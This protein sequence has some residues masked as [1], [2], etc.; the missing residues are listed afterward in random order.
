M[1]KSEQKN[2][3]KR[4]R[5]RFAAKLCCSLFVSPR[6][7]ATICTLLVRQCDGRCYRYVAFRLR[8]VAADG[9]GVN[10]R[11]H[12]DDDASQMTMIFRRGVWVVENRMGDALFTLCLVEMFVRLKCN[13]TQE[14][15]AF[16]SVLV[17][18]DQS[19]YTSLNCPKVNNVSQTVP[20]TQTTPKTGTSTNKPAGGVA[21]RTVANE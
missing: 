12:D 7:Y 15:D 5:I 8:A 16:K 1:K 10:G 4:N 14:N 20:Q 19:D 11:R 9:D 2:E 13:C 17:Q 21:E 3:K 6:G 18:R